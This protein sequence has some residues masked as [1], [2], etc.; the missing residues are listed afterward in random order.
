MALMLVAYCAYL[1]NCAQFVRKGLQ[2]GR[3]R[4]ALRAQTEGLAS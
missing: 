4:R 3:Q 2:A 1:I